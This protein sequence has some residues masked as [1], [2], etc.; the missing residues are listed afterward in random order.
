MFMND[1]PASVHLEDMARMMTKPSERER[2]FPKR[3]TYY[4]SP[5]LSEN[6]E[7]FWGRVYGICSRTGVHSHVAT[8]RKPPGGK[9]GC[10]MAYSKAIQEKTTIVQL[11]SNVEHSTSSEE[12]NGSKMKTEY[13]VIDQSKVKKIEIEQNRSATQYFDNPFPENDGTLLVWEFKRPLLD[14]NKVG[15]DEQEILA[16]ISGHCDNADMEQ[17]EEMLFDNVL[18]NNADDPA[19]KFKY[20]CLKLGNKRAIQK[21]IEWLQH[22]NMAVVQI[23]PL[24]TA[25]LACNTNSVFLGATE[26][27]KAAL[28]YI[29]K[30]V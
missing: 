2:L 3:F 4:K 7:R 21:A 18:E 24:A 16:A 5:L 25:L 23:T 29:I 8:C 14:L 30:Y 1:L 26:D 6:A 9:C 28:Y 17:T 10:R 19:T 27:A 15:I 11:A 12:L 13:N 20:A 22:R